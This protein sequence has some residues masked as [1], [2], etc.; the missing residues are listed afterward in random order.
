[1]SKGNLFWFQSTPLREGRRAQRP[2]F[3][4]LPMFQSTPL[5]EGRQVTSATLSF[6][7]SFNPRP[8]VRGDL[9]PRRTASY[10]NVSIHAP[11]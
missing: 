4:N 5:R 3:L 2:I 1:M 10:L 11:T 8:Y 7:G 6:G 9:L